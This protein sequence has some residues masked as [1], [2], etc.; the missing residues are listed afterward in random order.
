MSRLIT[1][2]CILA[3]NVSCSVR[4]EDL[5]ESTPIENIME[6]AERAKVRGSFDEAGDFYMEI[7]RL[8]PYSDESRVALKE[9]MKAYHEDSDLLN[10]RLSAQRYLTLYPNGDDA[11]FSRYIIGLSYFDSIVDVQRDQGAAWHAVEEFNLLIE[12]FPDDKYAEIA[13][14]KIIIANSQLAGQEMAVGRYYMKREDYLAA[15]NRFTAVTE[16]YS[17]TIFEVEAL[18]RLTEAYTALGL[19]T[20][21]ES[22]NKELQEKYPHS[23]WALKSKKLVD[24]FAE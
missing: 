4:P 24:I 2:L 19:E 23:S 22:N 20:L 21:A 18:Y 5:S 16:D 9:A 17:D 6:L 11:A 10:A 7:D 14:K 8:Y 1:I 12:L 13:R 3:L 15:L